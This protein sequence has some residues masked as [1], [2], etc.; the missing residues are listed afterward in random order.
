MS[1]KF[2]R[3]SDAEEQVFRD[4]W[5]DY[6]AVS[7]RLGRTINAVRRHATKLR[8]TRKGSKHRKFTEAERELVRRRYPSEGAKPIAIDLGRK[9]ADI[10]SV[11]QRMGVLCDRVRRWTADDNARLIEMRA[12]GFTAPQIAIAMG[13]TL[14]SIRTRAQTLKLTKPGYDAAARRRMLIGPHQLGGLGPEV[15]WARARL[16]L[17]EH[18]W[19]PDLN[20][21]EVAILQSLAS[22]GPQTRRNLATTL[23]EPLTRNP[24]KL[25]M[26]HGGVSAMAR[27]MA[28]GLVARCFISHLRK[29]VYIYAL[30]SGALESRGKYKSVESYNLPLASYGPL[31]KRFLNN[32]LLEKS[33]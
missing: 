5:P 27:L 29:R 18:G 30:T 1:R 23:G 26:T 12:K 17:G 15:R 24:K 14:C 20:P 6:R 25:L 16:A 32:H 8:L 2:Q 19:Q 4:L 31:A 11:A 9:S 7:A 33:A 28:R 10:V 22:R 13:R 3:Y 21:K